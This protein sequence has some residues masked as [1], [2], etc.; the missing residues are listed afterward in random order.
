[1][2][3]QITPNSRSTANLSITANQRARM[4]SVLSI[5][6]DHVTDKPTTLTALAALDSTAGLLVETATDTFTKRTLAG[7]AAE[8]AVTNVDGVA[9][10]PTFSLPTSLTF[11]G[12][13]V[14]GG[15]FDSIVVKGTWTASGTWTIP[16]VT[17]GGTI[18]GGGNTI[19]NI[20]IGL[21]TP[22]SGAFTTLTATTFNKV[23]INAPATAATINMS[24]N[25]ILTINNTL[26]FA[27]TD[28]TTITFQGT[29][30][31]V[32][33]TT[34]DTLTNKT[35]TSPV[36]TTPSLGVATATTINGVTLDNNAWT[37]YTPTV[38][39][40]TGTITAYTATG[41]YKQI[42]KT[43]VLETDVVITTVGTAAG[44][45]IVTL[46]TNSAA[47]NYVGSSIDYGA[48]LKSGSAFLKGSINVTSFTTTDATGATFFGASAKVASTMTYE[49]A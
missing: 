28:S 17:L 30:T 15:T 33:R 21:V 42:G 10:N 2:P 29:D 23:T 39:S 38:T 8:V 9:G 48:T 24:N 43:I 3:L 14:T 7:T 13:T 41:R 20:N 18:S 26:Q 36:L 22:L 25:K 12:K 46:P 35:L 16:A 11:T 47:F 40:Q 44:Q 1:M 32:G 45:M 37:T 19:N 31:Y 4:S 27:G 49:A 5:D 34:T 6:W